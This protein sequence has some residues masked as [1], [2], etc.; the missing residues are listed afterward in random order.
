M[1][2]LY[3]TETDE[4]AKWIS[5]S[6][7]ISPSLRFQLP[8]KRRKE[9]RTYSNQSDLETD[10]VEHPNLRPCT[11]PY[12]PGHAPRKHAVLDRE[13]DPPV[14]LAG[15]LLREQAEHDGAD[16]VEPERDEEPAREQAPVRDRA[17]REDAQRSEQA[18]EAECRPEHEGVAVLDAARDEEVREEER[19][20]AHA[21]ERD[22]VPRGE[23]AEV[24]RVHGRVGRGEDGDVRL[25]R[26]EDEE[27]GHREP[28]HGHGHAELLACHREAVEDR[29]ARR[30]WSV[31]FGRSFL[32]CGRV[33]RLAVHGFRTG[34]ISARAV[35]VCL[36]DGT[37]GL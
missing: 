9:D 23:G 24:E 31:G 12:S 35:R 18:R 4:L 15:Q 5:P 29:G 25:P 2:H 21:A 7:W 14:P 16:D 32:H 13:A 36:L 30:G 28:A 1:L 10:E 6:Q 20:G 8:P 34:L 11:T 19:E 33:L 17:G 26:A 22:E 27:A 37:L 3:S